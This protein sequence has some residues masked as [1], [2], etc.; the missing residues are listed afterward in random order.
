[1]NDNSMIYY[2]SNTLIINLFCAINSVGRSVNVAAA[3][4]VPIVVVIVLSVIIVVAI[5][6]IIMLHRR[7]KGVV[8]KSRNA[9]DLDEDKMGILN[10]DEVAFNY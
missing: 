4:S 8:V 10:N 9:H 2:Y 3:V 1:M 5:V 6:T 7:R